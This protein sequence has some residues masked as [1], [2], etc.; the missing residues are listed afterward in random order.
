M[1]RG[2]RADIR[3][4][5]YVSGSS[6]TRGWEGSPASP[7]GKFS[8]SQVAG[9][10]K[11]AQRGRLTTAGQHGW[12]EIDKDRNKSVRVYAMYPYKSPEEKTQLFTY[13]GDK[14][15]NYAGEERIHDGNFLKELQSG[16]IV[17]IKLASPMI[18]LKSFD[19]GYTLPATGDRVHY[20]N[21]GGTAFDSNKLTGSPIYNV[22]RS[23]SNELKDLREKF[24]QTYKERD[25][26]A[27]RRRRGRQNEEGTMYG[28]Y[29]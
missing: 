15:K 4:V 8:A 25:E 13:N 11:T 1:P 16:T 28:R 12:M 3:P 21:V 26:S 6:C 18:A 20:I 22:I 29:A 7:W 10:K 19:V 27:R 24:W 23:V 9:Q 2:S 14:H 17:S 5:R